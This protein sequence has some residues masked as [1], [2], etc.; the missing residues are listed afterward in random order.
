MKLL[1]PLF[2][3][4]LLASACG[5]QVRTA[6]PTKV[7]LSQYQTYAYLPNA[8]VDLEGVEPE[9]V[10][11]AVVD[12]VREQME[13]KGYTV[14]QDDPDLLVLLS[15]KRDTETETTT[16][17]VYAGPASLGYARPGAMVGGYYGDYYYRGYGTYGTNIVGYDTD[18]YRYKTGTLILH[19]VDRETHETVWKAVSE[20]SVYDG[21]I[22]PGDVAALVDDMFAEYPVKG[23][24]AMR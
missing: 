2:T 16:S 4:L 5:P 1:A 12:A 24:I 23:S 6:R 21:R 15:V 3:F 20:T 14:D 13:R 18:T 9:D 17:P 22:L 11:Q 8:M 10:N 19:L 7:D